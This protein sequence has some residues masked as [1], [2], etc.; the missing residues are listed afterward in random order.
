MPINIINDGRFDIAIGKDRHEKN[1]KNREIAWSAL[2]DELSET[3][4]T[5]E[6][7]N[8]YMAS[9]PA[10][11]DEIKDV[12]G[13]VGGYLAGGKRGKDTVLHRQL[14]TLDL[15][16]AVAGVW[17]DYL[18]MYDNAAAI[19]STHKHCNAKPRLRLCLPLSREVSPDEYQAI[20]RRIAG[21]LGIEQFDNTGFQPSRLMYWPS[22]AS[23]GDYFFAYQDGPWL[24]VDA[25]LGSYHDWRDSSEWPISERYN[26]IVQSAIKK[27][28]DPT[29][30]PGIIGA[31][32]RTYPIEAAI[33]T[34][35]P[36]VYTLCDTDGR[37][38][39]VGGSTTG[40]LVVYDSL[41][42]YSHHGTDPASMK[43]CNAFDL[44][45]IHKFGLRDED[46]RDGTPTNKSPSYTAMMDF[47]TKDAKVRTVLG[48]ERLAEVY[49][50][51]KDFDD[52]ETAESTSAATEAPSMDWIA[53]LDVDRKGNYYSTLDNIVII[54]ENDPRLKGRVLLN[55]FEQRESVKGSLPWRKVTADSS[56]LTDRDVANLRHYLEKTYNI[57]SAPKVEDALKVVLEK[58]QFHPIKDYL[59]GLKWDGKPRIETLL[60]EYLGVEDCEYV[61]AISRKVLAAAVSRIFNPGCKFDYVLTFVGRQGLKKSTLIDKL[62]GAWFSDSFTTVQGKEAYEQL[63]GSWLIEIAELAGMRKAEI[64][65]IK[66]FITKRKDRYR[67]A[68]GRRV[69]EFPRQCVFFATTNT[70]VFLRDTTGNRRW[71]P[72]LVYAQQPTKDVSSLTADEVGQI[73][74]EA[75]GLYREREL[76][77]LTPE[78]EAVASAMQEEHTETDERVGMVQKYLDTLLPENWEDL[79]VFE[80]RAWLAGD[81]LQPEGSIVRN[82]VCVPEIWCEILGGRQQDMDTNNTKHLHALMAN[83]KGWA[84]SK[85]KMRFGHYG[86]LKAYVRTEKRVATAP[87][88][89]ATKDF[90]DNME[91]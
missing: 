15:D 26:S 14:L 8:E 49:D 11:Q 9:K 4:R 45:R 84:P 24:D 69:E 16:H 2:V 19:Y 13:F 86:M 74:A 43:L 60:T 25:V 32:C 83:M 82:A 72:V 90:V 68:Y 28:G 70:V 66:H 65:T 71:W 21:N 80:R 3:K 1:W 51:F 37:Y 48:A 77:Y 85:T 57:S 27:Q 12:G 62:G 55:M 67:V 73:W 54:L 50:E 44:V 89:V 5:H 20:G 46:M 7:Y 47:C 40:G 18:V 38:T 34:F 42:A 58:N 88:N 81:E 87:K 63:Q 79:S 39:F 78:L 30:K 29:E 10:R 76:L 35:L 59:N 23:D 52:E 75:V 56:Y 64:E 33:A 22:T 17:D 36:D 31:F 61:R 6:S 53:T 41:F 91:L